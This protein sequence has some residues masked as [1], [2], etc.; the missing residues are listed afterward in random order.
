MSLGGRLD[1][2]VTKAVT[3]PFSIVL[4][5]GIASSACMEVIGVVIGAVMVDLIA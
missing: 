1:S 5:D 4:R 2:L 3:S